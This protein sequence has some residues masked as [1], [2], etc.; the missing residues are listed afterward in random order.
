LARAL[1]QQGN[2]EEAIQHYREAVRL[3]KLRREESE[4]TK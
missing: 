2:K 3:V 4:P 1:A